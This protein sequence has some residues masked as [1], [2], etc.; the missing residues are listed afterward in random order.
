MISFSATKCTFSVLLAPVKIWIFIFFLIVFML[1]PLFNMRNMW[2]LLK[3]FHRLSRALN[4]WVVKNILKRAKIRKSGRRRWTKKKEKGGWRYLEILSWKF[5]I[6]HS[7]FTDESS[8][9]SPK[10]SRKCWAQTNKIIERER[11]SPTSFHE[12]QNWN[13]E[14]FSSRTSHSERMSCHCDN[15]DDPD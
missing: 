2:N 10:C 13:N 9:F 7:R 15:D 4:A 8:P 12:Q 1:P 3:N 11:K 6:F 14:E 5:S